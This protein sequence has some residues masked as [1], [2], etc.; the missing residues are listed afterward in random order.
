MKGNAIPNTP[1]CLVIT[2][3]FTRRKNIQL[4]L[5]L[6]RPYLECCATDITKS[7]MVG[8]GNMYV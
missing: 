3:C 1:E 6:A 5:K 7:K 2:K 8:A 4:R